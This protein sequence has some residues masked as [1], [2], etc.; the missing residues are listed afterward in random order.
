VFR[1]AA[2]SFRALSASERRS[3][4][5]SRLRVRAARA[6][7]TPAGIAARTGST[8]NAERVAVA[9]EVAVGDRLAAGWAVKVALPQAY[10]ARGH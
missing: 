6:A 4:R 1:K 9:N 7:E 3:I 5:E 8:W 10:T 2:G